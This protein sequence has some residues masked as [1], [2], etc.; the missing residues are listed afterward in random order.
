M[1]YFDTYIT[2]FESKGVKWAWPQIE[3]K[4]WTE[5]HKYITQQK[6]IYLT[7]VGKIC[8]SYYMYEFN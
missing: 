7:I 3:A 5:A 8:L 4:S 6:L 2:E 1:L